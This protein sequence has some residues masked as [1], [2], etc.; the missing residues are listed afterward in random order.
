MFTSE[1]VRDS[2]KLACLAVFRT[3]SITSV[4][5]YSYLRRREETAAKTK[6]QSGLLLVWDHT[7]IGE[8]PP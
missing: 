3:V 4:D 7:R 2:I 5:L 1:L 6:R 8:K